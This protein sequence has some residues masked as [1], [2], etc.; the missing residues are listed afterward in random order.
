MGFSM[1]GQAIWGCLKYISN[2]N[3]HTTGVDEALIPSLKTERE[4]RGEKNMTADGSV[5]RLDHRRQQ[6]LVC[7]MAVTSRREEKEMS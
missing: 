4:S 1:G 3:G 2:R 6:E 5:V 7:G